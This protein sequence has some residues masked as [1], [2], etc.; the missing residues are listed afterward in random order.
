MQAPRAS[1][2]RQSLLQVFAQ[3]LG[4]RLVQL[5]CIQLQQQAMPVVR[6]AALQQVQVCGHGNKVRGWCLPGWRQQQQQLVLPDP[7]EH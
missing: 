5:A 2:H 3:L 1:T 7:G 6:V 4:Q